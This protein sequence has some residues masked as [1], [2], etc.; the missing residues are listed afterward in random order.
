MRLLLSIAIIVPL[1]AGLWLGWRYHEADPQSLP[2]TLRSAT[3]LEEPRPL[4]P[5]TL[6]DQRG[7]PFNLDDLL[8]RWSFLAIGYT[9][10]PDVCPMTMATFSEIDRRLTTMDTKADFVLISVDSER[11]TPEKLHQYV[12]YFNPRIQAATGSEAALKAFTRQLGMVFGRV[13]TDGSALGY[14]VDHSASVVL[15]DPKGRLAAVF[16]PPHDAAA[17]AQDLVDIAA[18]APQ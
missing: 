1:V 11:D 14:L 8:N 10:C 15:V 3:L 9:S 17:M 16:T 12:G 18:T 5:F 2:P 7:D 6:I 4:T 13:Q